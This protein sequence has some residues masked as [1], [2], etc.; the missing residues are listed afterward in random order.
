MKHGRAGHRFRIARRR[1]RGARRDR[2]LSFELLEERRVLAPLVVSPFDAV[3]AS[4]LTDALLLNGTGLTIVGSP[5][6]AGAPGQAGTY[7]GFNFNSGATTLTMP[8]GVLL[9]T[10]NATDAALPNDFDD[11]VGRDLSVP[12]NSDLDLLS[13]EPTEDAAALTIHFTATSETKAIRFEFVFSSEEFPEFVGSS[14]NDVFAVFLDGEQISVD[15]QD[16]PFTVNNNFFLLNNSGDTS[17]PDTIGKTPVNFSLVYDG[18]TRRLVTHATLD[19][20]IAVHTLKFVIADAS[21]GSFDSAVFLANLQG[22]LTADDGTTEVPESN[23]APTDGNAPEPRLPQEPVA[24][25]PVDEEVEV[26]EPV[27]RFRLF[28]AAAA[29]IAI[30]EA[31]SGGQLISVQGPTSTPQRGALPRDAILE[32]LSQASAPAREEIVDAVYSLAEIELVTL[33]GYDMGDEPVVRKKADPAPERTP[34]PTPPPKPAEPQ[35]HIV[36]KPTDESNWGPL[37]WS[38]LAGGGTLWLGGAWWWRGHKR[39]RRFSG[40]ITG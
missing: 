19:P 34:T 25:L 26:V 37:V 36:N 33:V 15:S 27:I 40:E 6:F 7:S 14:F 12:G 22:S 8:N 16:R 21:D 17:D 24:E 11:D 29:A 23:V 10:G 20:G 28:G 32:A 3:S 2:S 13:G 4:V 30:G 18:L 1:R 31:G 38:A 39:Q 5:L 9:T 35:T